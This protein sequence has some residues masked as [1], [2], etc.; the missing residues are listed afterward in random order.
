MVSTTLKLYIGITQKD[1]IAC[2]FFETFNK[3]TVEQM[4]KFAVFG[5]T[6]CSFVEIQ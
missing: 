4:M 6:K 2:Q 5:S 3:C 1:R